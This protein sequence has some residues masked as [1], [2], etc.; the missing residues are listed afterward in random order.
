MKKRRDCKKTI[1][2]LFIQM[3]MSAHQGAILV[4]FPT[5]SVKTHWEVTHVYA[6]LDMS[7]K[8][9]CAKVS[10]VMHLK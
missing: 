2:L 10:S 1:G 7:F 8:T 6:I 5:Q 4:L 9:T 3:W